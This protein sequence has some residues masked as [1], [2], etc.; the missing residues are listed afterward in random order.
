MTVRFRIETHFLRIEFLL[1]SSR[2][3]YQQMKKRADESRQ[4]RS[5]V[6]TSE[7]DTRLLL[8]CIDHTPRPPGNSLEGACTRMNPTTREKKLIPYFGMIQNQTYVHYQYHTP[9]NNNNKQQRVKKVK[10]YISVETTIIF[11]NHSVVALF[12]FCLN[13]FIIVIS[14]V[15]TNPTERKVRY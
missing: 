7:N 14:L 5:G 15:G 3:V 4:H 13:F 11:S 8:Y 10:V 12:P 2:V 9:T 6:L 1:S